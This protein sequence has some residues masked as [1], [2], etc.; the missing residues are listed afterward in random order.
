MSADSKDPRFAMFE[1]HASYCRHCVGALTARGDFEL[2]EMG[3]QMMT[4]AHAEPERGPLAQE[5]ARP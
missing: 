1:E 4:A 2:C 3:A 5:P